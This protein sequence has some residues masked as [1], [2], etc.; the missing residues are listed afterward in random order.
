[1]ADKPK[2]FEYLN[3][4]VGRQLI[5]DSILEDLIWDLLWKHQ[6]TTIEELRQNGIYVTVS[7]FSSQKKRFGF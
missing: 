6:Q 7:R 1:V 3:S 4:D 5:D 2:F